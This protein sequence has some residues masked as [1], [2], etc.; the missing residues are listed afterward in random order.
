MLINHDLVLKGPSVHYAFV[1]ISLFIRVNIFIKRTAF[2]STVEATEN[3]LSL[4]KGIYS[5]RGATG[6]SRKQNYSMLF[7]AEENI[8][9]PFRNP[10][11]KLS[12]EKQEIV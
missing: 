11:E 8:A 10:L 12:A 5:S 3:W 4:Q 2:I 6:K 9:N 1:V 7:L